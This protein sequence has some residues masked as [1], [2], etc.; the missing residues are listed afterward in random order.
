MSRAMRYSSLAIVLAAA[1]GAS[2]LL[3]AEDTRIE[4][5][6]DTQTAAS[7]PSAIATAT[8]ERPRAVLVAAREVDDAPLPAGAIVN[9]EGLPTFVP[10]VA[11]ARAI[12]PA[13]LAERQALAL[14]RTGVFAP[15]PGVGFSDHIVRLE[16]SLGIDELGAA[17][18]AL[19]GELLR[20][21]PQQRLATVRIPV[22]RADELPTLAG[23]SSVADDGEIA[24]MSVPA[25]EVAHVPAAGSTNYTAIDTSIGVAVIDTGVADHADLNIAKHV[26]VTAPATQVTTNQRSR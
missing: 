10:T 7:L 1:G 4:R 5:T 16:P 6:A 17:L 22:S 25:K 12:E 3:T 24:F 2:F 15:S 19:D 26:H 18:A 8:A 13:T 20:F 14:R 9:D 23:I 21:M 11:A